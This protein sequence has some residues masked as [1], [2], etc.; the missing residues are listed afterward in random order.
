MIPT[1][2]PTGDIPVGPERPAPVK[3]PRPSDARL[4]PDDLEELRR[5]I[6]ELRGKIEDLEARIVRLETRA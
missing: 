5:A 1:L 2:P 4:K 6:V 3:A